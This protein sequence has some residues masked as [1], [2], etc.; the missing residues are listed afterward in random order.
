MLN[1]I[2][3][4]SKFSSGI[5]F[6]ASLYLSILNF[7]KIF[8]KYLCCCHKYPSRS[9]MNLIYIMVSIGPTS[10]ILKFYFN[11]NFVLFISFV[12]LAI[13]MS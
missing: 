4:N 6:E 2:S 1:L 13:N 10:V 5:I 7:A 11:K 3:L 9:L 8:S 12:F